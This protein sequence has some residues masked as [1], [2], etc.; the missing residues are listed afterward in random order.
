[1]TS[2][3]SA[4]C[5]VEPKS[6]SFKRFRAKHIELS[7]IYWQHVIG[8]QLLVKKLK[9]AADGDRATELLGIATTQSEWGFS[10]SETRT[11]NQNYLDRVRLHLLAI[12]CA[13]LESFLQD[14]CVCYLLAKGFKDSPGRLSKSGEALG[15]PILGRSSLPEPM[16]YAE[17]LFDVAYGAHTLKLRRAYKYR[18]ALVH[19]GGVVLP[20]TIKELALSPQ[21]LHSRLGFSWNELK[22]VFSAAYDVAELTDRKLSNAHFRNEE[23]ERELC[24]LRDTD[25]TPKDV[26]KYLYDSGFSLP[27]KKD[28]DKLLMAVAHAKST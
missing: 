14:C 27:P 17:H 13:N 1:M 5:R 25:T 10:V 3:P 16:K 23:I 20:R 19:N 2:S 18:C 11:I 28:R 12:C 9:G 15:A 21:R 4:V 7:E 8:S 6:I 22:E 24:F 26:W